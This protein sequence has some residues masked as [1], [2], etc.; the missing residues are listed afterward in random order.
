MNSH[1]A[2]SLLCSWV[3]IGSQNINAYSAWTLFWWQS[4]WSVGVG[5]HWG[6]ILVAVAV[7]LFHYVV[8]LSDDDWT[9]GIELN[10][11]WGKNKA[12]WYK[13]CSKV[14]RR[15]TLQINGCD[16]QLQTMVHSFLVGYQVINFLFCSKWSHYCGNIWS[17]QVAVTCLN[18]RNSKRSNHSRANQN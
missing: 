18:G 6:C 12:S 8:L 11:W 16:Y 13:Q 9:R 17:W 7:K 3:E 4:I 10:C 14:H 2:C 1:A 5:T 15:L